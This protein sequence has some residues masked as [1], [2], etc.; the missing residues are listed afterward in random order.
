MVRLK[1]EIGILNKMHDQFQFLYGAIKSLIISPIRDFWFYFNSSMVRLKVGFKLV[2]DNDD[3][4]SIP[5]WCD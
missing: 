5:L 4:I 2:V 3:Y 1:E